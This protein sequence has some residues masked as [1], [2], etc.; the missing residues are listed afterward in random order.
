MD[1]KCVDP[2]FGKGVLRLNVNLSHPY[3]AMAF[4]QLWQALEL[5]TEPWAV[6]TNVFAA[7]IVVVIVATVVLSVILPS[8]GCVQLRDS[9]G[10]DS[11]APT[12][13]ISW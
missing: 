8:I 1:L 9:V 10:W 13:V 3:N 2:T 11:E 12:P 7:F 6:R 4:T 5:C